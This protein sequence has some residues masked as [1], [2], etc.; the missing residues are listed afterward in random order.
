MRGR[1]DA[2]ERRTRLAHRHALAPG[3]RLPDMRAASA[4]V[5][6]LHSSDPVTVFVSAWAR[7][8]VPAPVDLE[9]SLYEGRSLL[10]MLGMRRTLFVVPVE[11]APVIQAAC[12]SPIARNLRRTTMRFLSETRAA[13]DLERWLAE[14]EAEALAVVRRLGT[15]AATD[16]TAADA[17]LRTR[18]LMAEGKSYQAT[19]NL[20]GRVLLQ[21]GADG[22]IARHR[23]KGTW[24]SGQYRWRP[25]EAWLP[26]GMPEIPIEAA[27]AELVRRW[28]DRF[29]PG[30]RADLRWWTGLT[31]RE[32]DRALLANAAAEVELD[33]GPGFVLPSDVGPTPDVG[34][35]VALLP[36]LDPTVMGWTERS[37]Y[38]GDHV[39]RLFD[40]NGNA[41]PT[42]WCDGRIVGGWA[43]RR[44]GEIALGL[45]ED[46]GREA[47]L[48]LEARA[49]ELQA[50]VG[51]VRFT[52][53][54][55]S[56]LERE[57]SA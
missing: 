41:G 3:A 37:W 2:R 30:T 23:P 48:A 5:V 53:R 39:A 22:Y 19:Q 47:E 34:S 12:L 14:V 21:L 51:A 32:I 20:S 9:E 40:S 26:Q 44:D 8:G 4:A 7:T 28:L 57:L 31:A 42:A 46:V 45:L 54:F 24:I 38:L 11:L 16:V 56:P 17:R 35:W 1:F 49:A 33:S 6:G 29:G 15:A 52:P 25:I 43:Q 50:W 13:V 55:R 18:L 36:G 27:Q 10:R